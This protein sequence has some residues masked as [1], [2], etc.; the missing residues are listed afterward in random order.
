M[1]VCTKLYPDFQK[2]PLALTVAGSVAFSATVLLSS[3][4][5]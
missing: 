3:E 1:Y 4:L 2:S 5:V